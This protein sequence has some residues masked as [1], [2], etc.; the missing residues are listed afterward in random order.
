M[1]RA[2]RGRK[3]TGVHIIAHGQPGGL[4]FSSALLSLDTLER[5]A[6]DLAVLGN[7]NGQGGELRLWRVAQGAHGAAFVD[8]IADATGA[9]VSASARPVRLWVEDRRVPDCLDGVLISLY[10]GKSLGAA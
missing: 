1:A 3:E 6:G 9:R 8:A 4:A 5:N 7:S 10:T 2:V